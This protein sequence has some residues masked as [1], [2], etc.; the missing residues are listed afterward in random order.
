MPL[1]RLLPTSFTVT[2]SA[3]VNA[4]P[5]PALCPVPA[6]AV[7]LDGAPGL[8]VRLKLAGVATPLTVAVTVKVPAVLLAVN[9]AEIATPLAFVVAVFTPPANV[10]LAPLA[11][12]VKVTSIPGMPLLLASFTVACNVLAY[13]VLIVAF[14]GVPVVAV[15]LAGTT[16]LLVRVKLAHVARAGVNA[17]TVYVPWVPFDVNTGA[18]AMPLPLVVT[19]TVFAPPANKPVA[20]TRGAVNTTVAPPTG[21]LFLSRKM[22]CRLVANAVLRFAVCGVPALVAID[23]GKTLGAAMTSTASRL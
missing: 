16:M 12:A 20:P 19:V 9:T 21:L 18:V 14:C 13:A 23:V 15:M 5:M 17:A 3:V 10:P 4:L 7:T 11:G 2:C 6:V 22:T 1:N 8:F